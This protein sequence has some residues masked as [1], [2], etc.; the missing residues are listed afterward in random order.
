MMDEE[1]INA[2]KVTKKRRKR[3]KKR[4]ISASMD[5]VRGPLRDT[6][7]R[8]NM[9]AYEKQMLLSYLQEHTYLVDASRIL[10]IS[11]YRIL[12][13]CNALGIP[14]EKVKNRYRLCKEK[15]P[16]NGVPRWMMEH[17]PPP[18]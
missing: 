2:P 13:R 16:T 9:L 7:Y 11:A 4:T 14:T 6:V 3:R 17:A 12:Q 15:A 8:H 1:A 18:Q 10:G 5:P